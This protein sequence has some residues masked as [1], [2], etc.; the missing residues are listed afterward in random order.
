M[1]AIA[2]PSATLSRKDRYRLALARIGL[3]AWF[4]VIDLLWIVRPITF[5]I[6]ARHYQRAT[7][8]WLAGGDPWQVYE[9]DVRF[10]AGP[11]TLLFYAPTSL[12]PLSAAVAI[13]MVLGAAA[14][15]WVVRRLGVPIWWIAFPPL[16]HGIWNGNPQ[17]VMLAL[18]LIHLPIAPALAA[19]LKLYAFLPLLFRP[20]QFVIAGLAL[21]VTLPIL[22]WQ[23][24]LG[25][26]I[27]FSANLADFWHGSAWRFPLLV[28][29]TVLG[30]WVLRRRGAEWWSIPA[31]WPATQFYYVSTVL[32]VV[33]G[34]P[35]LAAL[36]AVPVPLMVPLIVIGLATATV[37]E[38]RRPGALPDTIRRAIAPAVI[39]RG[40]VNAASR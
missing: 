1:S 19:G 31:V 11:H 3:P 20:R 29:P 12:L 28:P 35:I 26:G 18:L 15:V 13:W 38:G 6:D 8:A 32:P 14:G 30:L 27:G 40:D 24:Y 23:L 25:S 22:P 16:F 4:V 21:A 10:L 37:V 5:A 9:Y 36:T 17:S 34:R 2:A 33:A 7:S 39:A